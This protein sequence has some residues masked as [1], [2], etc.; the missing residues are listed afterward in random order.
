MVHFVYEA[1]DHV[2]AEADRERPGPGEGFGAVVVWAAAI[3]GGLW[4]GAKE[5]EIYATTGQFGTKDYSGAFTT[6]HLPGVIAVTGCGAI[7][8]ALL[9]LA[10]WS[11]VA[12]SLTRSES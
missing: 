2:A 8:G 6:E 1:V 11:L 3:V 4:L 5:L 9:G 10:I 12:F 7:A